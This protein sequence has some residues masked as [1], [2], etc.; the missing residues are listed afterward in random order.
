MNLMAKYT[1]AILLFVFCLARASAQVS[2]TCNDQPHQPVLLQ[3]TPGTDVQALIGETNR[4]IPGEVGLELERVV[5]ERFGFYLLRYR[6]EPPVV[7]IQNY[8]R[9]LPGV[10]SAEWDQ[11][12]QFRN[13]TPDDNL[14]AQQWSLEKIALP[15]VWSVT[16]GGETALG[17]EIV[18]AIMDR[19]FDTNHE[20][21]LPNLWINKGE[22]EGDNLDND[23][24][25]FVDDLHGWNFREHRNDFPLVDHG[26]WVAGVMGAAANNATGVAAPSWK[27]KLMYLAVLNISDVIEALEYVLDQRQRYNQTNGA[28]GAF[29]VAVNGSFGFEQWFCNQ[30]PAWSVLYDPLGAQGVLNVAPP[31]NEDWNVDEL[32]DMPATCTSD[33]LITVTSSNKEDE[34]PSFGAYGPISVDLAAPGSLIYTTYVGDEYDENFGGNSLASPLVAGVI[35]LLYSL[36]CEDLAKLAREEPASAALLM[37]EAILNSVDPLP[38]FSGKTLTEGRINANKAME[39]LHAFCIARPEERSTGDFM[40]LYLGQTDIVRIYPNPVT[41]VLNVEYSIASFG[42]INIAIINSLGQVVQV[43]LSTQTAPFQQQRTTL[44]LSQLP[45]GTYYITIV[46]NED[47]ATEK[48]I[49]L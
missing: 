35:G 27:V 8:L 47:N 10:I 44:D 11:P 22:I 13:T 3:V 20:D 36:P 46:G 34:R 45:R 43:P 30:S 39:Y 2:L 41:D 16:T 48:F 21:L 42:T 4:S 29:V 28:E 23:N 26:T 18:I 7:S 9:E 12:V 32:G 24:N 5:S 6:N 37:K 1:L 15:P 33:Y 17:D 25:G 49:K 31:A 19:G 14:Y 38:A 40:E